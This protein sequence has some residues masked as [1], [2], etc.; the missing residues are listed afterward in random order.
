MQGVLFAPADF[1]QYCE[2]S[3]TT[4][5]D[6]VPVSR[7]SSLFSPINTEM[8]V[9]VLCYLEFSICYEI[10][11]NILK[12]INPDHSPQS[13]TTNECF[14][15]LSGLV[16]VEAPTGIWE[17]KSQ[18][19]GW[20][21]QCCEAGQFLTSQFSRSFFFAWP[22]PV[23][24]HQSIPSKEMLHLENWNLLGQRKWC[25]GASGDQTPTKQ[26]RSCG[27]ASLHIRPRGGV[28]L[29]LLHHHSDGFES[30]R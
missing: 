3:N 26:H 28:C 17:T 8:L 29:S 6:L 12:L 9:Q 21:L 27:D 14:L 22:S 18:L 1:K 16:R 4:G 20:L 23:L 2:L 7:V 10:H 11:D 5:V 13:E 25:G 15:F 24:W 19:C 30:K